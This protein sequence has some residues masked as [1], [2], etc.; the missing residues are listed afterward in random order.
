M[1]VACPRHDIP[2]TEELVKELVTLARW[3]HRLRR[4][5]LVGPVVAMNFDSFEQPRK[6]Q[7]GV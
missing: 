3:A 7:Q 6:K 5:H 1:E 4:L 2:D